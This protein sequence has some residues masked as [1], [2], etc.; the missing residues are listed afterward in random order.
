MSTPTPDSQAVFDRT[1]YRLTNEELAD[2]GTAISSVRRAYWR[3]ELKWD[4]LLSSKRVLLVSEAGCGKTYECRTQQQKL[5]HD[6]EAAFFLDLS[7]LATTPIEEILSGEEFKRLENWKHAQSDVATFFLDSIDELKLT[8]GK[9]DIALRRLR[10]LVDGQLARVRVIVTSRPVPFDRKLIVDQFPIP[11]PETV[12]AGASAFAEIA[13]RHSRPQVTDD[14]QE[15]EGWSN[16]GLLPL[17]TSQMRALA[18]SQH[19][20]NPDDLL[21]DIQ[22]R[23]A[24]EF[25]ERPQDLVELCA[26]WR[27]LQRIRSHRDQVESNVATK[28]KPNAE[29]EERTELSLER[30]QTLASR[31]ALAAIL[32]RK[33][34]LRH[35]ASSDDVEAS[36]SALDVSRLLPDASTDEHKTLLERPLFGFA[37][38]G[39]V[40]FHHRSVL[41]Y[42][43]AIRLEALLQRGVPMKS[44]KRLL[45]TETAQGLPVVRPSVRPVAAWL[46][47][48]RDSVFDE[49][50]SRDPP[51]VLDFGDPQSLRPDQ[52]I[53]ALDAF[54]S[55]YREGE[56]RGLS[57]PHIQVRRFASP[58]LADTI[59]RHWTAGIPNHEVRDLVL[60]LIAAGPIPE[61][62]D[63]AHEVALDQDIPA[64]LRSTAISVLVALNDPRLAAIS[65]GMGSRPDLWNDE[66]T[67]RS[68]VHLFPQHLPLTILGNILARVREDKGA[69]G[70]LTYH[71]PNLIEG[72]A[73]TDVDL[74]DLRSLLTQLVKNGVIWDPSRHPHLV[75]NRP[76]LLEA[77]FAVCRRQA[78]LGVRTSAWLTSTLLVLRLNGSRRGD[79][80]R[81]VS[82]MKAIAELRPRAREE[83]FWAEDAFLSGMHPEPDPWHRLYTI[84]RGG[85]MT[86]T[87]D[88]DLDWVHSRLANPDEPLIHRQMMLWALTTGLLHRHNEAPPTI[89]NLRIL[90]L[91]S[92]ELTTMLE[93][94]MKP[95]PL[96][97]DM[98]RHERE[99][100]KRQRKEQRDTAKAHASWVAFWQEIIDHPEQLFQD[101][102][103]SGTAWNL[104]CVMKRTGSESRSAGW[105]R[106]F[107]EE[108]FGKAVADRLRDSMLKVW[109]N[110]RPSLRSERPDGQKGTFLVRWQFGLA[111]IEAEAE[112]PN[113]AIKLS[114]QEAE[115]ACRYAPIQLNGFP[116]W[117]NAI[118][119]AHPTAIDNVL[120]EEISH[121]L[122]DTSNEDH[123]HV[124][125]DI[126]YASPAVAAVFLPRIR[127]WLETMLS[128]STSNVRASET[129]TDHAIEI[130]LKVGNEDDR[131]FLESAVACFLEGGINVSGARGWLHLLFRLNPARATDFLEEGLADV[132]PEKD[133]D[134]VT[135]FA[136]LFGRDNNRVYPKA[137]GFTPALRLR[138][139]K[140]A[141]RHVRPS[142]D[143]RHEGTYTPDT[144]DNAENARN[145]LL[146]A[147]LDLSGTEGWVT[148]MAMIDDPLL[149]H[150]ADRGRI[151]AVE[152]AAEEA[153]AAIL[154]D[155]EFKTLDAHGEAPPNMRDAMFELLRDRLDDIDDVLLQDTSPREQWALIKDERIMRRAAARELNTMSN[156]LY[157]V[158][159]E[160]ATADEKE[161]DI[162][163]RSTSSSQQ[164]TIELKIG[165][166]DRSAGDLH[167]ALKDQLLTKYMAAEHS[168]S[169]C[170][171]ITVNSDRSWR[172]PDTNAQMSLAM[173]IDFLSAEAQRLERELGGAVRLMVRGLDLRPRL[174]RE[175]VSRKAGA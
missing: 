110:D 88:S 114:P 87:P 143:V 152:K 25:A 153:D 124:L 12:T 146:G 165:E 104:W 128:G 67:R 130:V 106:A 147:V 134:A 31:L 160:A 145:N 167:S 80:D 96:S 53:R 86:L 98:A 137:P 148:K 30:A 62:A 68:F 100:A 18:V 156:H 71:L 64:T 79:N 9:F 103:A 91:D 163:L 102:R 101:T 162:R 38:Y 13:M 81:R 34:T 52:R 99:H 139:T 40:R 54:I 149:A 112:D 172:H 122:F 27:D 155:M 21:R 29:R 175:A 92:A 16:V 61:C 6:G 66:V 74:D 117:L 121:A 82:L 78:D 4:D 19:V 129:V 45:F 157:T 7:V 14:D 35:D 49:I 56:W 97:D 116:S 105:N 113:W 37:S 133:S 127:L 154:S 39:R 84:A 118:A 169:G 108:Q 126:N 132:V 57:I 85:G 23:N 140:L 90:V 36:E 55:R 170:L 144:R 75:T 65:E 20:T 28:L 135:W 22:R 76:D 63:I 168:K 125:Q 46:A 159:Q 107:I 3:K 15:S 174:K 131:A 41:E 5:W 73:S 151:L 161:T 138:L 94:M 2:L 42:L 164:A 171:M 109:R 111:A 166:K 51:I 10:K 11:K 89:E 95:R 120:G 141:Y 1:F 43:A 142:D 44:I 83:A 8:R 70:H 136:R 50:V 115:L 17:S 26:D 33:L 150:F 48:S 158:D 60:D 173:L 32:M 123:S 77:L 93:E 59:K 69:V 24:E 119:A 47:L 72:L 58:E